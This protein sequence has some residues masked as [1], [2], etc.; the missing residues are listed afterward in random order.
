MDV[1]ITRSERTEALLDGRVLPGALNVNWMSPPINEMFT[2]ML[3]GQDFAA[4]EMSLTYA[5][6]AL[7][8]GE[9]PLVTLPVFLD[10]TFRHR[11]VYIRADGKI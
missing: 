4:S 11:D 3:R 9:A 7:D 2:R 1:A 5:M 6:L 10:R 8:L